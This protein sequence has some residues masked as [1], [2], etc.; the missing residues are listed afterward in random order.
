MRA[1]AKDQRSYTIS[2]R[3]AAAG[4]I[5]SG[6]SGF[7]VTRLGAGVH[8]I[9][10]VLLWRFPPAVAVSPESGGTAGWAMV[11]PGDASQFI[12]R[13]LNSAGAATDFPFNVTISG[14]LL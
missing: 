8:Q 3:V 13:T 6:S 2:G 9:R 12:V 7:T 11:D 1:T 5:A 4:G 10:S 14:V